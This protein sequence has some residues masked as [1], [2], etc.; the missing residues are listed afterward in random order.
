M[1]IDTSGRVW[2]PS[3]LSSAAGGAYFDPSSSTFSPVFTAPGIIR[4]QQVAIDINGTVWADDLYSSNVAAFPGAAPQTPTVLTLPGYQ[5]TAL[6]VDDD[7]SLRFAAYNSSSNEPILAEVTNTN[8]TYTYATVPNTTPPGATGY[9][10]ASLAGD[11][12]GGNGISASDVFQPNMYEVYLDPNNNETGVLFQSFVDSG[13]VAFSGT[14]YVTARGGYQAS[15]DG[16]CVFST[17]SCFAMANQTNLLHPSG[18]AVDGGGN[19]WLADTY[20]DTAQQ[21][22]LTSGSYVNA[23]SQA[24]N[25]VYLHDANNGGTMG[26]LAGIGIDATGNVWASNAGCITS[27]CTP[28]SFVLTEIIGA[29]VPT[30]NPV[31]AQVVLNSAPGMEPS[32]KHAASTS[33]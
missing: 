13:Q 12:V 6:T 17:R 20:G 28:G 26:A 1:D 2:Y 22:P 27:G 19:L 18:L 29:G 11:L 16:I 23:N 8:N 10:G 24:A 30:I 21:I 7:N 4:P 25:Q 31:S 14:D 5:T 3:N 33:K 9:I 32:V 15:G